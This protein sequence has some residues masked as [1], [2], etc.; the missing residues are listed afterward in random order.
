MGAAGSSGRSRG[1]TITASGSNLKLILCLP[2]TNSSQPGPG[3]KGLQSQA[4]ANY[5]RASNGSFVLKGF[6]TEDKAGL[7]VSPVT[8][9]GELG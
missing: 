7:S 2:E 3:P 4:P 1:V 9:W 5:L 8:D 6:A